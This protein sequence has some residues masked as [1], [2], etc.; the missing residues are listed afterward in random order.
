MNTAA[1]N[2]NFTYVNMIEELSE[3]KQLWLQL[4]K[5]NEPCTRQEIC[6]K[7]GLKDNASG[8]CTE[9]VNLCFIEIVGEK[10][11]DGKKKQTIYKTIRCHDK[12]IN[13]INLKYVDLI[14]KRDSMI[15]DFHSGI[16]SFSRNI[17]DKELNKIKKL[18]DQLGKLTSESTIKTN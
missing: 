13:L 4:I 14:N 6:K 7:F 9:L 3:Q 15:S 1:Q 17:L 16:S 11:I 12:R 5:E 8:R 10:L 18:I 2:R